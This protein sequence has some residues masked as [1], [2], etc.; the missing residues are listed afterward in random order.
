MKKPKSAKR[1]V[2]TRVIRAAD[3]KASVNVA[4]AVS[5]EELMPHELAFAADDLA[6]SVMR[7]IENMPY[8]AAQISRMKVS[9]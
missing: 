1:A 6:G 2:E 7:A 3:F 5:S 8:I 9:K 4:I